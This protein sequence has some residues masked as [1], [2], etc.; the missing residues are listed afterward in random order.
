MNSC[1]NRFF[2]A[3]S[4]ETRQKMFELLEGKELP[5]G[6]I[7]EKLKMSQP[8]VSHHLGVLKKCGYVKARRAGK[9]IFYSVNKD[10]MV[11]CCGGFFG[12]FKIKVVRE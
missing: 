8:N 1:C 11:S 10:E 6:E 12:K 4:D 5:V 2:K 3:I 7:A 9:N